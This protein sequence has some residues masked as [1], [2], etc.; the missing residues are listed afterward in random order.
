MSDLTVST[1]ADR[2]EVHIAR[3]GG[4]HILTHRIPADERPTIHPIIAPDGIGVLTEDRPSHHPW[5][6]GLYTG[7]NLVNGVGFWRDEPQDGSFAPHL[8]GTPVISNGVASW[9]LENLWSHP[10]GTPMLTET[11]RWSLRADAQTYIIDLE[12]RLTAMIDIEIGRF[13]AGGLFLRMPYAPDRG[14]WARN[15]ERME[16]AAAEKQRARWTAVWMPIVG[17]SDCAGMAI[18]D[19]PSN[20]AYPT[21]WRVDSEY[22]ISPSRVIA[23]SWAIAAGAHEAYRYRVF[24]FCGEPK[25]SDIEAVWSDFA[26]THATST[27]ALTAVD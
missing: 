9:S 27:A 23:E 3:R 18:M 19:H 15:S 25:D 13:M 4:N 16:N 24:T 12:W 8:L 17:R 1:S 2:R 6:R 20:P 10:D 21:T 26:E 7:F 5:Q 14:A 11:Q 22:G